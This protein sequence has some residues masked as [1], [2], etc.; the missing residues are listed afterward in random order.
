MHA[1]N[2]KRMHGT[3]E[4]LM[5][6]AK[7]NSSAMKLAAAL[8]YQLC[9]CNIK[10]EFLHSPS[11]IT[12]CWIE[13]FEKQRNSITC[14]VQ[15]S[16]PQQNRDNRTEPLISRLGLP[17]QFLLEGPRPFPLWYSIAL[18]SLQLWHSNERGYSVLQG[19]AHSPSGQHLM[20]CSNRQLNPYIAHTVLGSWNQ[21]KQ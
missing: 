11:N 12:L 10:R 9:I 5:L 13:M 7:D 16:T 14:D 15:H 21:E 2:Y 19:A 4:L 17:P 6:N 8:H 20:Q 3:I 18:W 1:W